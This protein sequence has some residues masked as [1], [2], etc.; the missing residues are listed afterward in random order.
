MLELVDKNNIALPNKVGYRAHD[1]WFS[2]EDVVLNVI[3]I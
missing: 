2:K 1:L 3:Q